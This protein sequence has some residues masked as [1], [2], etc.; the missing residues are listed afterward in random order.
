MNTTEKPTNQRDFYL[1]YQY[2]HNL[3]RIARIN[4]TIEYCDMTNEERISLRKEKQMLTEVC[5]WMFNEMSVHAQ[6]DVITEK[7]ANE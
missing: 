2:R 3:N 4:K 7:L 5:E 6:T 1:L